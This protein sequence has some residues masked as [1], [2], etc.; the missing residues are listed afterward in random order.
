[1]ARLLRSYLLSRGTRA[2]V[3]WF[4]GSHFAASLLARFLSRFAVFKGRGNP[5]YGIAVPS[6]LR[7]MWLLVEFFS[8]LPHYLS[9]V[10]L[11]SLCYVVGDRCLLDFIVWIV[12]TLDHPRFLSSILGRFLARLAGRGV[13]VYVTADY[14]VLRARAPNT[15]HQ[16]LLKEK[17][18]YDILA[19]HYA[20]YVIDTTNRAPGEALGEL[21]NAYENSEP[22]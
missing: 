18:C 7:P 4:R 14:A 1:M 16:F 11:S 22:R 9:R 8:L 6:K 19:R 5:Y 15:P 20:G 2:Y 13:L 10:F 17:V 21:V 12:V 3:S